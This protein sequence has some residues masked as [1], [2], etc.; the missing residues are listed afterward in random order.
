ME[1]KM[2]KNNTIYLITGA[3]GF[4]GNNLTNQLLEQGKQV[5]ALVLPNDPA[6]QFISDQAEIIYGDLC[7]INSLEQFF[8]VPSDIEIIVIHSA[9]IVTFSPDPN[10]IV[11]NVNVIGTQNIVEK[12]LQ[13]NAKKLVYIS[14]TGAIPEKEHGISIS[15]PQTAEDFEPDSVVGYYS[16]TKAL[17]TQ[18]VIN[19]VKQQGLNASIVYPTGICGPNDYAFGPRSG[20]IVSFCNGQMTPS[21]NGTLNSVDVRDLANGI[22]SCTEKGRN[23][24]GYIMGNDT[25][26]MQKQYDL[27]SKFTGVKNKVQ[28]LTPDEMLQVMKDSL[29]EDAWNDQAINAIKYSIYNCTRNNEFCSDKARKELGFSTRQV[30]GTFSDEINWLRKEGKL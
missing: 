27:L 11:Y 4:L 10:Q 19:A 26:S 13:H 24:E 25:I 23:G 28:L 21:V 5:R 15:E 18:C 22:I 17:A 12:C 1:I 8:D 6:A 14:S 30:E 7:D 16:K 20:A 9:S 3:A 2:M 29:P